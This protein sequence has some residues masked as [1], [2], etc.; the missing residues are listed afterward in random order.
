MLAVEANTAR[1]SIAR[2]KPKP[3]NISDE[4]GE[5]D[6]KTEMQI[7]MSYTIKDQFDTLKKHIT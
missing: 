1:P 5:K 6:I 3:S 2:F 4:K 7:V